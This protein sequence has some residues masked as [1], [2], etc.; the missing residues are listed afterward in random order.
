MSE[1]MTST[2]RRTS[3]PGIPDADPRLQ[4]HNM[5]ETP[6]IA[7]DILGWPPQHPT[8]S[9]RSQTGRG[10]RHARTIT[11]RGD[12]A[13]NP[14]AWLERIRNRASTGIA[15]VLHGPATAMARHPQLR[16]NRRARRSA[17]TPKLNRSAAP[18]TPPRVQ[19]APLRSGGRSSRH[20][21][22]PGQ[23]LHEFSA[24]PSKLT[25]G[26]PADIS[27]GWDGT[28]W[29]TDA[30][31]AP[32]LYDSTEQLWHLQG[33]GISAAAETPDHT[34]YIFRPSEVAIDATRRTHLTQFVTVDPVTYETGAPKTIA[35]Q[36]PHLP[37]TFKMGVVGAT[38]GSYDPFGTKQSLILFSGGRYVSTDE[39]FG[40]PLKL[41][42]LSNWPQTPN[43]KDG[44]IDGVLSRVVGTPLTLLRGGELILVDLTT[45]EVQ[46]PPQPFGEYLP[47][48]NDPALSPWALGVDAM[49]ELLDQTVLVFKGPVVCKA[50]WSRK[51]AATLQYIGNTFATWPAEWNPALVHAPSGRVG[52]LWSISKYGN[53]VVHHDGN[54]WARQ[55]Y[56]ADHVSAGQDSTVMIASAGKIW[57][58]DGDH[59]IPLQDLP[60]LIQVAVGNATTVWGRTNSTD[61]NVYRFDTT[62]HKFT[63]ATI[64]GAATDVA[65]NADG[66]LWHCHH[67]ASNAY[68]FISEADLPSAGLPL[69]QANVTA[70]LKLT[71]TGFGAAHCLAKL[72]D[73]GSQIYRY[74]SPYLFKTSGSYFVE[75]GQ[76]SWGI[77]NGL[78][79]LY[80]IAFDSYMGKAGYWIIA[81]DVHTGQEVKRTELPVDHP[82]MCLFDAV[83]DPV[84]ELVYA[85]CNN[86]VEIKLLALDPR[87]LTIKWIYVSKNYE[88]E[89]VASPRLTL[90]G[91]QLCFPDNR[92]IL[93]MFDTRDALAQ[94]SGTG[95]R[96]PKPVWTWQVPVPPVK[97][98]FIARPVLVNG[99]VYAAVWVYYDSERTSLYLA[100]CSAGDGSNPR[101]NA[102]GDSQGTPVPAIGPVLG[103]VRAKDQSE[104]QALYI[105][106]PTAIYVVNI[107][108]D[109]EPI[110]ASF[111]LPAG[112]TITGLAYDDGTRLGQGLS[113]KPDYSNVRI[114]FGDNSG[115]LWGLND[116]LQ[117]D[118]PA[119]H[120]SSADPNQKGCLTTT[121]VIYKDPRGGATL[122]FGVWDFSSE[123]ALYGY[124]PATGNV[125]SIPTGTTFIYAVT[126]SVTNGI[127][128]AGG[129]KYPDY[130]NAPLPPQLFGMRVDE[131]PQALRS[132]VIESQLM[133]DP[134]DPGENPAAR[135]STD[136]DN[137]IPPSVA[138]YQ[139]HLTVLDG[140]SGDPNTFGP[141]PNEP[142]KIW[143]DK[144]GTTIT[145]DT[146]TG[147][148][149]F[150]VG[151]GDNEYAAVAT[152]SDGTL[153]IVSDATDMFAS[154][155]R[156]WASFM[157]PYERIV[158]NP[159][160]EFHARVTTAHADASNDDPD[161]V[162]LATARNYNSDPLF[163]QDEQNQGQPQ[164]CAD[165]VGQMNKGVAF[166]E[167][168]KSNYA[169]I[170]RVMRGE[171]PASATALRVAGP[172][173]YLAYGDLSGASHFPTNI[174]ATRLAGVVA[175]VGLGYSRP[176]QDDRTGPASSLQPAYEALTH[177]EALD[178]IDQLDG[179]PWQPAPGRPGKATAKPNHLGDLWS[180]F[181]NWLTGWVQDAANYI[182][183]I[184]VAVAEDVV[185][186]IQ[187]VVDGITKVFKAIIKAVEDIAAAIGSFFQMLV[188]LIEDV[189]AALS[190]LFHF[191]EIIKTHNWMRDQIKAQVPNLK[192]AVTKFV[193]P[194]LDIF[195]GNSEKTIDQL[196]TELRKQINPASSG[197]VTASGSSFQFNNLPGSGSTAH[198]AF[199]ARAGVVGPDS[200]SSSH[201]VQATWGHQKLKSGLPAAQAV[202]RGVAPSP[203]LVVD[204]IIDFFGGFLARIT[205]DGDLSATFGKLKT[206]LG[207]LLQPNSAS[208]FFATALDTLL[209]ILQLLLIGAMAVGQACIGGTDKN[210]GKPYGLLA[211]AGDLID[212]VMRS[213][214]ETIEIPVLS[215]LYK[216]LFNEDLT[217]L[218]A[219]TLVAAIP[220][221]MLYRVV[222]GKYP[223]ADLGLDA[224]APAEQRVD[225]PPI[226]VVKMVQG[227]FGGVAA[228]ALGI[229]RAVG[230]AAAQLWT[231]DLPAKLT[232]ALGFG[233]AIMYFPL[234][235]HE[236]DPSKISWGA[237]AGWG[238][239]LGITL[240][241]IIPI[242]VS[243]S[244][245]WKGQGERIAFWLTRAI[246]AL[247]LLTV[248]IVAFVTGG[249]KDGTTDVTFARNLVSPL[250]P[251]VTWLLAFEELVPL[252]VAID[253]LAG[254]VVCALNLVLAF[255]PL[256]ETDEAQSVAASAGWRI[257]RA[258]STA[259]AGPA[260]E[261]SG[262]K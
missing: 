187:M 5:R 49:A 129:L 215:W 140:S 39:D 97:E 1:G 32:H 88:N 67:G 77:A 222:Q 152:G 50:S 124:D 76:G 100:Q 242:V 26:P 107:E 204:P 254:A 90:S 214:T 190:V 169:N 53:Y 232:L 174:P 24:I 162:N 256:K 155:L 217:I 104:P 143:S 260:E 188:K 131:L 168:S 73:G 47:F 93:Y 151:P 86:L 184:V 182:E 31:G 112:R 79:N 64:V 40:P 13:I 239:G 15:T 118:G 130:A 253:V 21:L 251:M 87:D 197:G 141:K 154:P 144:P 52:D 177:S 243:S 18:G 234:I 225:V 210:T 117:A 157:D 246:L 48:F 230:D 240:M 106:A 167:G 121:P 54:S 202:S 249:N 164:N 257:P 233:Y 71:S 195:F 139:T 247:E 81:V 199:T 20:W 85:L 115:N 114:W 70:V 33:Q 44:I 4:R 113:S 23:Q 11:A 120:V 63:Q 72:N 91:T 180:D 161:K 248:F 45:K 173:P 92:N 186:G 55:A 125:A 156:V 181:W 166:G 137:P 262:L 110:N 7:T 82:G 207:H 12:G 238:M 201:A 255:A 148:Q 8:G 172:E 158:V 95:G 147:P 176:F 237:W 216:L 224:G 211:L 194:D 61:R 30:T 102:I 16:L 3:R 41:T 56:Q 212:A 165:A 135:G 245:V 51:A 136:P 159:D 59:V 6:G 96:S 99:Q 235:G 9:R 261:R 38:W 111:T 25:F 219:I 191:G 150:T 203:A 98:S 14:T 34:L 244:P 153:V 142:V 250:P 241:G 27:M 68:R 259:R 200:G 220:V 228:L 36:W 133:Q 119:W 183:S 17:R 258:Q 62:T 218:N 37:D 22:R 226:A 35:A 223:S 103:R 132:F 122:L 60:N 57:R 2:R 29:A 80:F 46:G 179:D 123:P 185:V 43:W 84:S 196:F 105:S 116:K 109:A 171:R 208:G 128:Y 94:T 170:L 19:A 231:P 178:L 163:T 28:L 149:K 198:T 160:Q 134:Q 10:S 209:D 192:S 175:H 75:A 89:S 66:T 193:L 42:D 229:T 138:R 58:R 213:L 227:A 221:T 108:T 74:D 126:P 78:G 252:V 101:L 205:G 69:G 206:D 65:A 189:I 146:A 127:I 236:N 83:F 145:I